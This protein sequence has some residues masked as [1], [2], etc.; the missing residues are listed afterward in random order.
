MR[1]A[2]EQVDA[3][4]VALRDAAGRGDFEAAQE[5]ATHFSALLENLLADLPPAE[6]AERL[7]HAC[8]LLGW[9]RGHL[10][11]ARECF[12]AEMQRLERLSQYHEQ[13]SEAAQASTG[14]TLKMEG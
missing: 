5:A 11:E 4:G 8:G 2:L 6:A 13:L 10:R 1:Q 7:R 3:A 14:H 12:A 9:A